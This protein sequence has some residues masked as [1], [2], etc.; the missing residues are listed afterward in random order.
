MIVY[1]GLADII[2]T[3]QPFEDERVQTVR[4][5][6]IAVRHSRAAGRLL[7]D[8]DVSGSF[9]GAVRRHVRDT[10]WNTGSTTSVIDSQLAYDLGLQ[11]VGTDEMRALAAEHE[12]LTY[13]VDLMLAPD[14]E[15]RNLKVQALPLAWRGDEFVIGMDVISRGRLVVDSLNGSTRMEFALPDEA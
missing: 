14:L 6:T 11:P 15:I 2:E 4:G 9:K 12:S 8:I 3:N 5:R 13:F 1:S 7:S 10:V